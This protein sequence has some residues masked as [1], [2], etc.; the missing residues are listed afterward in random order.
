MINCLF[1]GLSE[2]YAKVSKC[3]LSV[4]RKTAFLIVWKDVNLSKKISLKILNGFKNFFSPC[5]LSFLSLAVY[6]NENQKE[7]DDSNVF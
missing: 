7:L 5:F 6:S 2:Q 3:Y 4:K 1:S